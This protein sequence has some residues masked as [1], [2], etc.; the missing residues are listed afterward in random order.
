MILVNSTNSGTGNRHIP[1]SVPVIN[2][3]IKSGSVNF[4]TAA[5]T[6]YGLIAG[7]KNVHLTIG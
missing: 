4:T 1:V 5:D 3:L 6:S 7:L 2:P